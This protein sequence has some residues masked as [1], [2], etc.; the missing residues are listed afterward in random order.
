MI[1]THIFNTMVVRYVIIIFTQLLY[2]FS[3]IKV[4]LLEYPGVYD[5]IDMEASYNGLWQ[6]FTKTRHKLDIQI[7]KNRSRYS[8]SRMLTTSGVEYM[9]F[10]L[11]L[12]IVLKSVV[13]KHVEKT[14]DC[15]CKN[16]AETTWDF[17]DHQNQ[18]I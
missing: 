7:T 16:E 4:Q 14:R 5:W 11:L 17:D 18:L 12:S 9:L 10:V 13:I 3:F 15:K 1:S 2:A 6:L 8:F